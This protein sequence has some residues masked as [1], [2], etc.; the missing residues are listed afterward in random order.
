ML[1]VLLQQLRRDRVVLPVWIVGT[2]ALLAVSAASVAGEYGD[3][4]GR[5]QILTIALATPTLLALRGIPNGDSLGSAVHFQSFAFLA[6]TIGLMNVFL[7][8]RHGRA[9]EEKGRRELLLAAPVSRLTPPLATLVLALA[10][11]AAFVVLAIGGYLAVGLPAGGAVLGAVTLGVT[12]LLFYGVG[13]TAGELAATSRAASSIGVVVVL[14]AYALRA[15]GDALGTPDVATLTL[16]PAWPSALSPIGWGQLTLPFTDDRWWPV[17][18]LAAVAAV[19]A[20]LA[21]VL[22]GNRE[23]GASLLPDRAGR[24]SA[25]R[26]LRGATGLAWRLTRPAIVWWT[27]GSALLGLAIGS[28]V[29]AVARLDFSSNPE[30]LQIMRS[31]GHT[32]QT[33]VARTLI[34]ALTT[35]VGVVAAAAGVQCVL[36]VREEEAAGRGENVLAASVSR[37]RYLLAFAGLGAGTVAVVLLATGLAAAAGFAASGSADFAWL[38]LGQCLVQLPAALVFVGLGALAVGL[39]PRAAIGLSWG[40]Y[41]AGVVIGFFGQLLRLPDGVQRLS[42][43]TDTPVLPATA[44]DWVPTVLVVVA[45]VLAL[46][47]AVPAFRRRDLTT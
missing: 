10:G 20:V 11:N 35:I 34:P 19:L 8:T 40:L 16:H 25:G 24:A 41:G 1:P 13:A 36:R 33:D 31:I 37:P 29:T 30:L 18:P 3:A 23:L 38:A 45:A 47:V 4:A 12:G 5:T 6:V 27:I 32:D 14:A 43:F 15:A 22:H 46:V 28:L 7:A 17:F 21:L 39:L 2:A 44:D 9:D 42:P 26:S